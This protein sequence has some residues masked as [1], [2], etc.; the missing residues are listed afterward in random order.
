MKG[1]EGDLTL[2]LNNLIF[3]LPMNAFVPSFVENANR[4]AVMVTIKEAGW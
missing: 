1:Y 3:S 2:Y 4:I